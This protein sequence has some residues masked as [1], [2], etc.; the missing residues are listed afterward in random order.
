MY[1]TATGERVSDRVLRALFLIGTAENDWNTETCN[2]SNHCGV[3]QLS[4]TLQAQ[5]NYRDI[6]YWTNRAI[7][8]G[9]YSYGGLAKI[10]LEHPSWS[11]GEMVQACQGAGPT[12]S[13]AVAYYNSR[14]AEADATL[15][16]Y[17]RQGRS[18]T[19]STTPPRQ[20]YF[21]PLAHARVTPERIDQGVDYAGTGY[22]VAIADGIVTESIA[23]GSGWEGEGYLEYKIT[24]P[25][26]LEGVYI[27]Y[28]EGVNPVVHR[29]EQIR[30]GARVADLREPM[31]HGIELGFAAGTRQWSYYRYHDGPYHEGDV[32]RPGL[33]FSNLVH[34][35]GGPAGRQEGPVVG[36]FPEYI[37][38]GEPAAGVTTSAEGVISAGGGPVP[39]VR[40]QF[41][42][43]G[44]VL[45]AFVQLQRGALNGAH[46]SHAAWFYARGI[47][48]VP[49][50]N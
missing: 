11:I 7:N 15:A 25:G 14:L 16:R 23:N 3:F 17:R 27:Y 36:N 38:S 44:D 40:G 35:L 20:L 42:W 8:D 37:Q 41:E 32:T 26:E 13:Q 21:N 29:G 6:A 12:W 33:A 47:E 31:P 4:R 46:H 45:S 30:G 39:V 19:V 10:D 5:H 18:S 48:Y 43:P 24:Q 50:S 34:K 49:K 28:A 1:D 9:F 22:L 2:A